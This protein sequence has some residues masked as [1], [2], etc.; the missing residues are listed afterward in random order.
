MAHRVVQ[1]FGGQGKHRF[2]AVALDDGEVKVTLGRGLPGAGRRMRSLRAV[3][4][5]RGR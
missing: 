4:S 2:R 1:E 5:L 3:W